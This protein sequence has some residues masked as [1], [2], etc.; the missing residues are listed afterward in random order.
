[1][2]AITDSLIL[3]HARESARRLRGAEALRIETVQRIL[4]REPLPPDQASARL[5]YR[6]AGRHLAFVVWC[7]E[8]GDEDRGDVLHD[9]AGVV[10][11]SVAGA[12]APALIVGLQRGLVAGWVPVTARVEAGPLRLVGQGR[13]A[14]C[15]VAVGSPASGPDGFRAGHDEAMRARRVARLLGTNQVVTTFAEVAAADLLTRDVGAARAFALRTL[16]P[17]TAGDDAS[18]R[19]LATLRVYFDEGQSIARTGRRLGLSPNTVSYRVHR[20]VELT[21]E[22]SGSS[23]ALQAAALLAPLLGHEAPGRDA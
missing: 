15:L 12:G 21:G 3:H 6:L 5:G 18:R 10:A 4:A 16:G 2:D 14:R 17:L 9:V 20:A 8:A 11:R 1:V 13:S 22:A 19:L 23:H 7:E